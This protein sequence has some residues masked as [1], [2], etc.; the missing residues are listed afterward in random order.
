MQAGIRNC[1][2]KA[3]NGEILKSNYQGLS[4]VYAII[5]N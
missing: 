2:I 4:G 5:K 3:K 1:F